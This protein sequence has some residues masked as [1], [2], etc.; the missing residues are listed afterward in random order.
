MQ[1]SNEI[2]HQQELLDINRDRLRVLV[3]QAAKMG[4]FA[5]PYVLNEI[6]EARATIARIKATL[7]GWGVAVEDLPVDEAQR[8]P[9]GQSAFASGASSPPGMRVI[10]TGGGDYI[11]GNA[12]KRKGNIVSDDQY[13]FSG[14]FRGAILNANSL[15]ENVIQTISN[16]PRLDQTTRDELKQLVE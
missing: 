1:S 16:A 12:D 13:N 7:R 11:E 10:N 9:A 4:V 6:D 2:K 5:P 14:D 3:K 15:L 8:A